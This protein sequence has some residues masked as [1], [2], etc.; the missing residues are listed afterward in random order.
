ML[1]VLLDQEQVEKQP[2]SCVEA[3][4][5]RELHAP[6]RVSAACTALGMLGRDGSLCGASAHKIPGAPLTGKTSDILTHAF[7]EHRGGNTT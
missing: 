6:R 7:S 3:S 5:A 2:C 1:L 4:W